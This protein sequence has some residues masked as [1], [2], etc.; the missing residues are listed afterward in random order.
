MF[1]RFSDTARL[2]VVKAQ[3]VARTASDT[4]IRPQH[5]LGALIA[6]RDSTSGR[7][8]FERGLTADDLEH[9]LEKTSRRG[10]VTDA[11]S[12]ALRD[13]GIDVEAVVRS[14]ESTHGENV[15]DPRRRR[16]PGLPLLWRFG[17]RRPRGHIPFEAE[18]K[19]VLERALRE[20][21]E[22]GDMHIGDEHLL[23]ALLSVPV[24]GDVLGEYGVTRVLVYARLKRAG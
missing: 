11:D 3:E 18:S 20:A 2:A 9:E 16:R 1:E 4:E 14:V 19:R 7:L 10:G 22:R 15:L 5:L 6:A 12:A 21:I 8:L 17:G 13:L 24:V 23:L